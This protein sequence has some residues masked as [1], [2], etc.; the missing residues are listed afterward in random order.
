M[1]LSSWF[2]E[3]AGSAAVGA[4]GTVAAKVLKNTTWGRVGMGLIGAAVGGISAYK[5]NGGDIGNA[6]ITGV[7][8]GAFAAVLG[9]LPA[10][11]G[12]PRVGRVTGPLIKRTIPLAAAHYATVDAPPSPADKAK[13]SGPTEI[14]VEPL[15][16]PA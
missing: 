14:P 4:V 15:P 3:V 10:L 2:K 11:R 16:L 12:V 1:G 8:D 13:G 9:K 7:A 6:L 5:T